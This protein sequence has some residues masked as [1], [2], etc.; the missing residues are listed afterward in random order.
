MPLEWPSDWPPHLRSSSSQ[1]LFRCIAG[2]GVGGTK[3]ATRLARSSIVY[4]PF[5]DVINAR[6]WLLQK[7]NRGNNPTNLQMKGQR[8]WPKIKPNT[9]AVERKLPY[10]AK[11]KQGESVEEEET[12]RTPCVRLPNDQ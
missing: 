3:G 8:N 5:S 6:T 10:G 1:L 9:R 2:L 7:S 12:R 11:P 4:K